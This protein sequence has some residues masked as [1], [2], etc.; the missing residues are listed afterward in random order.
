[1]KK[2]EVLQ[3]FVERSVT[4]YLG[5]ASVRANPDGAI[6]FKVGTSVGLVGLKEGE[7]DVLEVVAPVL[8]GVKRS[9]KLPERLNDLN[10]AATLVRF[11]WEDGSV[12]ATSQV[13]AS[14]VDEVLVTS[15]CDAVIDAALRLGGPLETEF[16]GT[17]AKQD[18]ADE[19][20]GAYLTA[21]GLEP[22]Y[23]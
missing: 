1:M 13:L 14:Q 8:E 7:R 22:G 9:A 16:G 5:R 3:P 4:R 17:G 23:L 18:D 19:A 6:T 15:A 12:F 20:P 11:W 21:E 2:I 10:E